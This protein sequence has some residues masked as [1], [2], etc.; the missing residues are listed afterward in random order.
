M[1]SYPLLINTERNHTFL[2]AGGLLN[3]Y[4]KKAVSNF[5]LNVWWDDVKIREYVSP[6]LVTVVGSEQ[7]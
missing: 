1:F 5:G 3:V 7:S 6:E 4:D 2:S